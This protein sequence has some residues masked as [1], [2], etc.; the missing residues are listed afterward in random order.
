MWSLCSSITVLLATEKIHG[1]SGL[2]EKGDVLIV[3]F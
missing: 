1:V 2:F 3:P